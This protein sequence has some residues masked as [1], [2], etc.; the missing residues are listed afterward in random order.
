[1]KTSPSVAL[2]LTLLAPVQGLAQAT[3][4][5][6]RL[7][8][9]YLTNP[10]GI[11]VTQPR[12]SWR[13]ASTRRN[14]MQAAYQVQ[15][16]T[17]EANL[18]RGANLLWDSGKIV[19]DASVFVDYAG[20]HGVSRTRYFWRVRVWDAS[21]RASSWSRMA[22]WET[23]LLRAGDWAGR[24][25]G[26]QATSA[27]SL[28]SSS[29]LLRRAFRVDGGVRSA[30]VYVTSLGL[31]ELYLNGQRVGDQLFTPGWTSY[32]RRLQYQTYDVTALLRRGANAMGAM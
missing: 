9:E 15:V 11:D 29:P 1:M 7:R 5:V 2:Y 20:P 10:I 21:G 27:D 26:P 12:L 19:S 14:T 22:F 30:R 23:G 32:N 24:W 13:I 28:P 31:Y 6:D 4:T 25:I 16:D 8:V 17:S 3:P 18:T